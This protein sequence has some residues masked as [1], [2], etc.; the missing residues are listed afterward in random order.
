MGIFDIGEIRSIYAKEND[1]LYQKNHYISPTMNK[2]MDQQKLMEIISEELLLPTA[3]FS[4]H[5][6]FRELPNWS[7]LNALV[8]L[9]RIFEESDVLISSSELMQC[10]TIDD[11]YQ[12]VKEANGT[13]EV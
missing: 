6:L 10:K 4:M 7:S 5:A 8:I 1:F 3:S 13:N 12:K 11:I 9:S 2:R